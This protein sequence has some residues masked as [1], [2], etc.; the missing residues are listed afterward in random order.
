MVSLVVCAISYT[1][2]F[3]C[4]IIYLNYFWSI[5]YH[6][7]NI[8]MGKRNGK[9]KRKGFYCL[10][11]QGGDF[12]PSEAAHSAHR[13]GDGGGRCRGAGPHVS[14]R[15]GVNGVER[16]TE[17]GGKPT[18]ARP[19]V[20]PWVRFYGGGAVARHGRGRGSWRWGQFDRWR[21]RVAGPWRGGGCSRW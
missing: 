10:L 17:G 12:G 14:E 4:P 7:I 6:H 19:P 13:R 3:L 5:K 21:P 16:A 11:G 1:L 8:Y 9:R 18:G 20:K 15:R 2:L